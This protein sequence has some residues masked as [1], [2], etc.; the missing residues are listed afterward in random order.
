MKI[1]VIHYHLKPGGVTTVIRQQIKATRNSNEF[2]VICGRTPEDGFPAETVAIEEL[3]YDGE[4]RAACPEP[5]TAAKKI[6][7][8]IFQ[9]WPAGCDLIHVHN[10]LLAKNRNFLKILHALQKR[11]LRLF[12][13]VHDFAE[14]GRPRHYY[15]TDPY[16]ADC[17]YGVI[18]S[19]DRK[20][21]IAA[22]AK[23]EG[24]HLIN[25]EVN[26]FNQLEGNTG[27][28][29]NMAVYPV[30]AIRRKNIGETILLS[31]F[32]ENK[33]T[34]AITLPPNSEADMPGYE[35][36]KEFTARHRLPVIFE[37]SSGRSFSELVAAA[38]FMVT[39][40]ITEGFGFAFLEPWT[41]G[42]A[43]IGR[44]LPALCAD[45]E[46]AGMR[47]AHLYSRLA[48]PAD[49]LP[50]ED[51]RSKVRQAATEACRAFNLT[52]AEPVAERFAAAADSP[53]VDFGLLDEALQQRVIKRVL[54]DPAA[55]R[56]LKKQNP[57]LSALKSGGDDTI[58]N[59][60][61]HVVR[62]A[63]NSETAGDQLM[64]AYRAVAEKPVR[65][66]ID[67]QKLLDFF[68]APDNFSLLQWKTS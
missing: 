63:Y 21:L 39:T 10:P 45:F 38:A 35:S 11:G 57:V 15:Q 32:F 33:E 20:I 66:H 52:P 68:F 27:A 34:L 6:T 3:A 29:E 40:S 17:H 61:D 48:V 30:R 31:L 46:Q 28:T 55:R 53:T 5:D 7:E 49:W 1:A 67:K 47:L 44:K 19:R 60:N 9:K 8:A 62:W 64:A 2:L 65:Q 36:W 42:K 13:Q 54:T 23:P 58:I 50:A 59:H 12:L 14:D 56:R 24:V 25:N 43:L 22:G 18:N 26:P 37:A 41:A 16:P 4:K 51:F